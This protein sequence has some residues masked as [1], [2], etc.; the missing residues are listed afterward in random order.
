MIQAFI[1]DLDGT[2][3][4]TEPIRN[5]AHVRAALELSRDGLRAEDVTAVATELIGVPAPET[6][7]EL[8]R[9]LGLEEPARERMSELGVSAPWQAYS[10]LQVAAYY[11]LLDEANVQQAQ[12]PHTVALLYEARRAG[13][14]TGLATMSTRR[15][16]Q[17]VLDILGWADL[18]DA[19]LTCDEVQRGK[20]DPEIYLAV[21]RALGVAPQQCLVLED[22]PSGIGSA[23]AAGM[24][25]IAV[26]SD[27]TRAAVHRARL[28]DERWIVDDPRQ[29]AAVVREMLE[30]AD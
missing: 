25:C 27:L 8:V 12:F 13:F 18:F 20:P 21:A 2:L 11:E 10:R 28:L 30:Q 22:S 1:F 7:M 29:L 19:V 6:A 26:A 15:E 14:K 23:L 16:T 17:R 3:A 5:R 4:N 24:W 9:R